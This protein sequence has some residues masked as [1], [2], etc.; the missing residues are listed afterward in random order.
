MIRKF[1]LM[2][3]D[4]MIS[5]HILYIEPS[6]CFV[7]DQCDIS[8]EQQLIDRMH[9]Y[10]SYRELLKSFC[11]P[12]GRDYNHKFA[13]GQLS[14]LRGDWSGGINTFKIV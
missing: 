6:I 14:C 13:A 10:E 7:D 9:V 5:Y 1:T 3:P 4:D 11:Q 12:Y 8:I 2:P